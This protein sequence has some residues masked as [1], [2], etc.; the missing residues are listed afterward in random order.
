MAKKLEQLL[1]EAI[2]EGNIEKIKEVR[3]LMAQKPKVKRKYT[4]KIKT[5]ANKKQVKI[6]NFK[7]DA[8]YIEYMAKTESERVKAI[9]NGTAGPI[10]KIDI[11]S[12]DSLNIFKAEQKINKHIDKGR[13]GKTSRRPAITMSKINCPRC[14]R[15]VEVP[16]TITGDYNFDASKTEDARPLYSCG[17]CAPNA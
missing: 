9:L 17:F 5:T 13:K 2:A 12:P 10:S 15:S 7:N 1:D 14:Q 16:S 3:L 8:E 4:K 11:I 6:P